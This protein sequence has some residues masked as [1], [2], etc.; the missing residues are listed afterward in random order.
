MER[1]EIEAAARQQEDDQIFNGCGAGAAN[2]SDDEDLFK[3][4]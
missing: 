3:A 1:D 4:A 2:V